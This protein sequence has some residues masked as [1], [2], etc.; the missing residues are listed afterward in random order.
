MP[1]PAGSLYS[2]YR[3]EPLPAFWA[4]FLKEWA[5]V[6]A[7]SG[8]L[9]RRRHLAG[10]LESE[11]H[12]TGLAAAGWAPG[13]AVLSAGSAAGRAPRRAA[14]EARSAVGRPGEVFQCLA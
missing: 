8:R 9:D 10:R 5:R 4:A 3:P 7:A 11:V 2:V 6:L 1:D 14:P 12:A 13:P